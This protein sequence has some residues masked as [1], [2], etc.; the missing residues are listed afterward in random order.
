MPGCP[1]PVREEGSLALASLVIRQWFPSLPCGEPG[2]K[3]KEERVGTSYWHQLPFFPGKADPFVPFSCLLVQTT[4]GAM[5][6][7]EG[8]TL[9]LERCQEIRGT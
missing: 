9:Y 2:K 3:T 6:R 1:G 4:H 5:Q 7:K 8:G